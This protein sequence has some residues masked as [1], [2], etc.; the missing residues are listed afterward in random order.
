VDLVF[1]ANYQGIQTSYA[2]VDAAH[3]AAAGA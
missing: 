2:G 1:S 3:T